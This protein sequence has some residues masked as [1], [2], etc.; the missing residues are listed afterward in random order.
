MV[1]IQ[2]NHVKICVFFFSNKGKKGQVVHA[3]LFLFETIF[4]F[5]L[6]GLR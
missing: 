2:L 1:K 5:L 6:P 4:S 3:I